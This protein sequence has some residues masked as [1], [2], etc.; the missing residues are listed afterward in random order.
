MLMLCP[1]DVWAPDRRE[2]GMAMDQRGTITTRVSIAVLDDQARL[3]QLLAALS[4]DG[5]SLSQCSL[6]GFPGILADLEIPSAIPAP[7]RSDLVTL[8]ADA[9]KT[10]MLSHTCILAVRSGASFERL[11]HVA[12]AQPPE[13]MHDELRR[14]LADQA[15][16]GGVILLVSADSPSQHALAAHLLLSHGSHDLHTHEFSSRDDT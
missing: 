2:N 4:N 13:W 6:W 10:V 15:A 16:D 12:Q 14:K 9:G 8:L 5:V 11:M 7:Q 1:Q 3:W